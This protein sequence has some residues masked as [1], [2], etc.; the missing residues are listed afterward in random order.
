[1]RILF[2]NPLIQKNQ[3][4]WAMY[5]PLG[6]LLMSAM[7]KKEGH[8]VY[9]IDGILDEL[10]GPGMAK[11]SQSI[12][13]DLIGITVNVMQLNYTREYLR[14]FRKECKDTPIVIGGPFVSAVRQDIFRCL[15]EADFAVVGE[16]EYALL[17]LV[18]YLQGKMDISQ[19][20]GLLYHQDEEVKG[21]RPERIVALDDL[22][23]PD[24]SV[25]ERY[26]HEYRGVYPS[27]AR[28]SFHM[29]ATRGCPFEC[30]FCSSPISW[31]KQVTSRQVSSIIEEAEMLVSRYGA[32]EIFL[33][34]DT[35]N[36]N[37]SWFHSLCDSLIQSGLSKSVV[38]KAPLRANRN[39]L[40]KDLLLKAKSANFGMIFYGVESGSQMMLDRLNKRIGKDEIIRAFRLTHEAGI[41][42]YASFMVG[43]PG[44]TQQ[45]VHESYD[46]VRCLRADY[47]GFAVAMPFPGTALYHEVWKLGLA[48]HLNLE[49]YDPFQLHIRTEGLTEDEIL[50]YAADGNELIEEVAIVK[51]GRASTVI[52]QELPEDAFQAEISI[53]DLPPFMRSNTVVELKVKVKN[54]GD[55]VWPAKGLRD[56]RYQIHLG[57]HW[58]DGDG[59]TILLWDGLRTPLPY[60]IQSRETIVLNAKIQ[61]PEIPGSYV[62]E[63][64]LVQERVA[65]FSEKGSQPLKLSI[66]IIG[67]RQSY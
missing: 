63:F 15:G 42:S 53:E 11:I 48:D 13:P 16:G 44:E 30:K 34:D 27:L 38:L 37:K 57:Y 35:L 52:H 23:L 14:E 7:L 41:K 12:R 64:D 62:I 46:L 65:W 9:F 10:D 19:V 51:I 21:N 55:R 33:Q 47:G 49:E 59:K 58:L 4:E 45:T 29:M 54:L 24:Y 1:M 56:G 36:L 25:A 40:D 6:I 8:E 66:G 60:D 3:K 20:R 18:R 50:K 39:L 61:S 22:P 43:W 17:D 31:G 26:L 28:P 32:R 5:A 2:I 67:V